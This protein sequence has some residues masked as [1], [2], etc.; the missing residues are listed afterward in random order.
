MLC[1]VRTGLPGLGQFMSRYS[2]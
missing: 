1:H 2:R